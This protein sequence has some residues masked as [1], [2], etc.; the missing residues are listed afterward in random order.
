M[1]LLPIHSTRRLFS[2]RRRTI[3][4]IV[5]LA[6]VSLSV[7]YTWRISSDMR[8]ED[9][10]SVQKLKEDEQNIVEMWV[11][12]VRSTN[13]ADAQNY[14]ILTKLAEH[15]TIPIAVTD[16]FANHLVSNLPKDIRTDRELFQ[17]EIQSMSALNDPITVTIPYG[18]RQQRVFTI[19]YGNTDYHNLVSSAHSD[20]LAFFPY[21]QLVIIIIFAIFAY[22]VFL[23]TKQNEQNRVWVGLAKETAHQLGTPTSSLLGWIEYM[24]SQPVDQMAVEE[25]SKDLV[26]LNKIVDRFSKIG[27]ETQLTMANIN[28]VVGDTVIYF[29]RR[30]PR[31]VTLNYNGLTVAPIM[32]PVNVALFEWVVEN[33]LKNS[34]D[35]LQGQGEIDVV[36]GETE[37]RVYVEVTDTGK[38][39]AKGNWSRIFEPGF[40]TK[41]R[42]WGLGL[43]L[44]RRIIEEYHRGKIGVVRSEVGRGTT[45]RVTLKRM[46]DE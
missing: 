16:D 10:A 41:T 6:L 28:E 27:S 17:A 45:I 19:Y 36:V 3:V 40:T 31:N 42:G 23:S 7:Y 21:V 38:G 24:R 15:T 39:I 43:S 22:I 46:S 29:R 33:L 8:H 30:I 26:H 11:D 32:V 2:T 20:A 34:L 37:N 18:F 13:L 44:S 4:I 14:N 1:K 5:G 9:E 35:A 25:M 12:I